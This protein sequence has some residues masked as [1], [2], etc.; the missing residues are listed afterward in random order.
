MKCSPLREERAGRGRGEGPTSS[1]SPSSFGGGREVSSGWGRRPGTPPEALPKRNEGP[2]SIQK[3]IMLAVETVPPHVHLS[4][5]P[6][7]P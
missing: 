5:P 4:H 6:S 1:T 7:A 2:L 3:A